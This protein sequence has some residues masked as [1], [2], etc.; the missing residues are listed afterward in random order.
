MTSLVQ[1]VANDQQ[2]MQ[3]IVGP[4]G[5]WGPPGK[6]I[7]EIVS[8]RPA[9]LG[10][11][12]GIGTA[13]AGDLSKVTFPISYTISGT[14][15]LGEPTTGYIYT[16]EASAIAAYF[17]NESGWNNSTNS[18]SGRTA[19]CFSRIHV[20][21]SG[22]GDCVAFNA[23]GTVNSTLPGASVFWA[24]PAVT[25]FNGDCFAGANGVFLNPV[26]IHNIDN[27]FDCAAVNYVAVQNRT[28]N[29]GA[30]GAYWDGFRSDATGSTVAIN[31]HFFGVGPSILGIDFFSTQFSVC[32]APLR[33]PMI[34]PASSSAPGKQGMICW[35]VNYIYVC[36]ATN[37]WQ[38]VALLTW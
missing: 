9:T 15:T 16:P 34:T 27:G 1:Q 30:L 19:A 14:A 23:T 35:D 37:T 21:N 32:G 10:N 24:N 36:T 3:S 4:T 17:L 13:F 11:W 31:A 5:P 8:S 2:L 25:L 12:N 7:V 6:P 29:A 18:S 20:Q 22:Q 38:R 28:Q 26:E 33:A